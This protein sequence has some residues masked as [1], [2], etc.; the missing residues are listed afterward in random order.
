MLAWLNTNKE[1]LFSGL[2]ITLVAGL[3][4]AVRAAVSKPRST[5]TAAAP[6]AIPLEQSDAVV[7]ATTVRVSAISAQEIHDAIASAP[8]MQQEDKA[9]H[10]IGLRVQW[11]T[12]LISATRRDDSVRLQLRGGGSSRPTVWC[13]VRFDEYRE[14]AILSTN[15][16]II[17]NGLIESAENFRIELK[18]VG[19]TFPA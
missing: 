12:E 3:V 13:R 16:P 6:T 10:F 14:L 11:R 9:R 1:W 8:P 5:P 15:S 2:G 17:V 4:A 18:E 7:P 19:L